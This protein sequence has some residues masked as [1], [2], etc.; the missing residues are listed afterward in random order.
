METLIDSDSKTPPSSKHNRPTLLRPSG[1][2]QTPLGPRTRQQTG[3][4]NENSPRNGRRNSTLSSRSRESTAYSSGP[5]SPG[6]PPPHSP[7]RSEHDHSTGGSLP[8]IEERPVESPTKMSSRAPSFVSH[9]SPVFSSTSLPV[10]SRGPSP[11]PSVPSSSHAPAFVA[12]AAVPNPAPA[13]APV[14]A[15]K[16]LSLEAALWTF[17]SKELQTL[18]SRA[19]RSSA[20]ETFVRLLSVQQLDE[21][22]PAELE[23]LSSQKISMQ[24]R[25][26]FHVQRRSMLLQALISFTTATSSEKDGGADLIGKLATQISD[27]CSECDRITQELVSV[28]DQMCQITKVLENHWASALAIAL[29]K[30][31]GSYGKRTAE[32]IESKAKVEQLEAELGDAWIE[33]EKLAREMDD[34]DETTGLYY[35]DEDEEVMIRKAAVVPIPPAPATQDAVA[36][37]GKLID[38]KRASASLLQISP[39]ASASSEDRQPSPSSR[40][41]RPARTP[42][43]IPEERE[44]DVP[45]PAVGGGIDD[46]DEDEDHAVSVK[47]K[48]SLRSVRSTKSEKSMGGGGSS[49]VSLVSAARKRSMRA[50]LGSLRLP[51]HRKKQGLLSPSGSIRSAPLERTKSKTEKEKQTEMYPPV[52]SIPKVFSA[53]PSGSS[54]VPHLLSPS[55]SLASP[56]RTSVVPIS[57]SNP[58]FLNLESRNVSLVSLVDEPS[59]ARGNEDGPSVPLLPTP[60][61]EVF[62]PPVRPRRT[63]IDDI[64]IEPNRYVGDGDGEGEGDAYGEASGSGSG[65]A[66]HQRRPLSVMDDIIVMPQNYIQ[67]IEVSPFGFRKSVDDEDMTVNS[68]RKMGSR[69]GDE[70]GSRGGDPT[71]AT[72]STAIPSIWLNA[73]TPKTPSERVE[74]LMRSR[75]STT[76]GHG[77]GSAMSYSKLKGLTKR[78]SLPF[79]FHGRSNS[80]L[81]AAGKSTGGGS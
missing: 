33:A 8:E 30:L 32:L 62:H 63:E 70:F 42:P 72:S 25:Y 66:N 64:R 78:Y 14:I 51:N 5:S 79:P 18:V 1:G 40:P 23:R 65:S 12:H 4:F 59:P 17:N 37:S 61:R 68:R 77:S 28:T 6:F 43:A 7:F 47:S 27:T 19:I 44:P 22:L 21:T 54:S 41:S 26:R 49:R 2:R 56:S 53:P 9:E 74:A 75:S 35:S 50:S 57:S 38:F 60:V 3:P 81:V 69:G 80:S 55:S 11:A 16:G 73:D 45:Q 71:S 58:S 48:R 34:L 46:E 31:N 67:G 10:P 20:T 13:P 24:A 29:R 52:P 76:K 36:A 15:W 39:D